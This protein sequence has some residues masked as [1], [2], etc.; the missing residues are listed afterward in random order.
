M[1]EWIGFQMFPNLSDQMYIV[2]LVKEMCRVL[3]VR[4]VV[5]LRDFGVPDVTSKVLVDRM[6][7][8]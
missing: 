2:Q 5:L 7:V 8:H 1:I 4:F 3:L 6:S